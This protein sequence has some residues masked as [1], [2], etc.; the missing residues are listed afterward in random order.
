MIRGRAA[1]VAAIIGI[2]NRLSTGRGAFQ[3]TGTFN[4]NV[5]MNAGLAGLIEIY[6]LERA[7]PSMRGDRLRRRLNVVV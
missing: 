5:T 4:N 7:M 6:T 2:L 3:H 1:S